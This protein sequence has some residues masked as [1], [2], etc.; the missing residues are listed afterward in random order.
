MLPRFKLSPIN[1]R[2]WAN[3][4]ANRR[5]YWSL[6]LFLVL[7]VVTLFAELIANDR[8]LIA[9]YKGETL[10]PVLVDYPESKFGGFL[11][12]TDYRDPMIIDE[13]EAN[14]WMLW[15]PIRYSYDTINKDYPNRVDSE[16]RC[17]IERDGVSHQGGLGYPAPPQWAARAKLCDAPPDQMERYLAIGNWNWLG[18]DNQG[19]DVLARVIYGFRISVL[20]GLILTIFSSI[21]GI[22]AGAVQGY[23]G[24]W[25]DL[26]MQ[27]FL[28]IWGNIPTLYVLIIIAA[29][30]VPG[31]WTLLFVLLAFQWTSLVGVVRA[32]FLRAR[33]FEYVRAARALGLSDTTIMWK[34]VLPNAAVATVT[35]MP[36]QLSGSIT[37]L[38]SLDFLGLGLPPGSPSL[39]ELLLQGKGDLGAP[40][41][42]MSAFFSIAIMLSLLIFIFEG[43]RDAL[44]P[45]KTFA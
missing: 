33:N 25:I 30:L 21:I 12:V 10:F 14:G 4:K 11:A 8:P 17:V 19:R 24:G 23:Y 29:V 7:F 1:A 2:R 34:H 15:P 45:R 18:L 5:G 31:F 44:D 13:I 16:G 35:F 27:R 43:V 3:F 38:T 37:T 39:G 6:I 20:F 42:G 9:R 32:E 36:F 40:W 41:L 28:E 26:T 22:A